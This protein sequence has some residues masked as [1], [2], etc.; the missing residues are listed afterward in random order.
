MKVQCSAPACRLYQLNTLLPWGEHAKWTSGSGS[1]SDI[2]TTPSC[3]TKTKTKIKKNTKKKIKEKTKKEAEKRTNTR[4]FW[5][6]LSTWGSHAKEWTSRKVAPA[7]HSL[8]SSFQV[9][10]SGCWLVH[11]LNFASSSSLPSHLWW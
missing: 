6:T 2:T 10:A 9:W 7:C 11:R 4:P 5:D 8:S 1:Y 3:Q